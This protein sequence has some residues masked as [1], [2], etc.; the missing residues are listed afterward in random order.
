MACQPAVQVISLLSCQCK[1]LQECIGI[2]FGRK[3]GV[4]GGG[5]YVHVFLLVVVSVNCAEKGSLYGQAL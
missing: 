2:A 3:K 5:H 1:V 4:G